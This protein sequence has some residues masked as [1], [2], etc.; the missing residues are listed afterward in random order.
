[1]EDLE[2]ERKRLFKDDPVGK[3]MLTKFKR[4]HGR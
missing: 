3:E 2:E 1:M 4:E